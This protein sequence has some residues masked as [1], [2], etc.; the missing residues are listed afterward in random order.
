[1]VERRQLGQS[2]RTLRCSEEVISSTKYSVNEKALDLARAFS[3][4]SEFKLNWNYA[5]IGRF[6]SGTIAARLGAG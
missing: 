3:L 1:M 5:I 4:F 6:A 2:R